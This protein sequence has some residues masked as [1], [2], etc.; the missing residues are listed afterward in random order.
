MNYSLYQAEG[1]AEVKVI[2]KLGSM[3]DLMSPTNYT[4]S[5]AATPT[6]SALSDTSLKVIGKLCHSEP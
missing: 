2:S 5:S 3:Y 6:V 1:E 4:F